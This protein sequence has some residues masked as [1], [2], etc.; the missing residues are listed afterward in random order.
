MQNLTL[1]IPTKKEV[2]SLPTFLREIENYNCKKLIVLEKE[3]ME[4]KK[5]M[6]CSWS[7]MNSIQILV[8]GMF[9]RSITWNYCLTGR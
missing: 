7:A 5:W 2:E 4:T 1:I 6:K 3:D 9:R 8:S